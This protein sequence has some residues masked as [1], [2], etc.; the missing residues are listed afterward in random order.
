M[1]KLRRG[2]TLLE[3]IIVIVILGIVAKFGV[4][5]LIRAYDYY[6]QSLAEH[7]YQTQSEVAVEQIANRLQYRLPGSEIVRQS[8]TANFQTTGFTT[9]ASTVDDGSSITVLEWV[10]VDA[11]GWRGDENSPLPTWS[12][13]I[14]VEGTIANP[15][16]TLLVTRGSDM[17]R[18]DNVIQS[19]SPSRASATWNGNGLGLFFIQDSNFNVMNGFGWDGVAPIADQNRTVHPVNRNTADNNFTA[20]VGNFQ[21]QKIYEFYKLS[22]TAYALEHD[23]TD[24][25][26]RVIRLYYDYRPWNGDTYRQRRDGSTPPSVVLMDNVDTFRYL[27]IGDAIKVQVCVR[28]VNLFT[29]GAFSICKEKT[30]F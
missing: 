28:D 11:D 23:T 13:F 14:D 4:E 6:I 18:V 19:L 1:K 29:T 26:H 8:N 7:R 27:S 16:N 9:L 5:L 20:A 3:L 21:G 22:W 2:F 25:L 12:G 30:V 10:G 15:V 24:P 17:T